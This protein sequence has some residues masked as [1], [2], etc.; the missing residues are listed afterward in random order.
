[1]TFKNVQ[2]NLIYLSIIGLLFVSCQSSDD[3]IE[4]LG[5][6]TTE[7]ILNFVLADDISA[8]V[9]DV[10]EDDA[11]DYNLS[12]KSADSN[13]SIVAKCGDRTIEVTASGKI[14][15][16][17]FGTGCEGRK[18]KELAGKI[19]IEYVRTTTGFSKTV[20]FENF[21]V[22][23]NAV[24]GGKSIA[25][26]TANANGNPEA[27]FTVDITITFTTGEVI[28]KKGTKVKEKIAGADTRNRGDDV[29]SISGNWESVNKE[30]VVK[31]ASITI[32]LRREYACK[33]IVSGVIE[34]TK[35][36]AIST[37]DFGD[38]T[39]DNLATLTDSSGVVTEITLKRN[40]KRK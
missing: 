18:G 25:K 31:N 1:M 4:V 29:Y 34:I 21:T 7:E 15:T 32:N 2:K 30:G 9:D 23:G 27:T 33:Y 39:C 19:I 17:D 13:T 8:E 20:S 12:G 36:T 5:N 6:L 35:G 3:N 11:Q 24:E 16:L 14:V 37:L 40:K 10:L 38:G 22:E 28:T 26:S